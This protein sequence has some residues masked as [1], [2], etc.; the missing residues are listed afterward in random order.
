MARDDFLAKRGTTYID[1]SGNLKNLTLAAT[2]SIKPEG[3]DGLPVGPFMFG[4]LLA[5][6]KA[7][8]DGT[9]MYRPSQF[10]TALTALTG[11]YVMPKAGSV[12][13]LFV[14][15]RTSI[16]AATDA[17]TFTVY[18]GTTSLATASVA[19]TSGDTSA[20]TNLNKD[21]STFAAG[22]AIKCR[23]IYSTGLSTSEYEF[24]AGVIV[25]M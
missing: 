6:T 11:G 9:A 17:V 24:Q 21:V 1:S 23:A 20:Y 4:L 22:D 18:K 8:G 13:G 25:E 14:Q 12:I 19:L 16:A 3:V 15:G 2:M 5:T 10:N 7:T